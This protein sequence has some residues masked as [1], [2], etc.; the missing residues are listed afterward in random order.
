M[1]ILA[2]VACMALA[3]ISITG[4]YAQGVAPKSTREA[5]PESTAEN[6]ADWKP[7]Q[8][9]PSRAD[10]F[11]LIVAAQKSRQIEDHSPSRSKVVLYSRTMRFTMISRI[12]IARI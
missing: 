7:L 3:E 10:L 1:K 11:Q 6:D 2:V 4:A 12:K 8:G 9:E 5:S